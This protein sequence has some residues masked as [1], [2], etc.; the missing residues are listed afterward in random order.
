MRGPRPTLTTYTSWGTL[1]VL[2]D[3]AETLLKLG[4]SSKWANHRF[5]CRASE[6]SKRRPSQTQSTSGPSNKKSDRSRTSGYIRRGTTDRIYSSR[7][8]VSLIIG[9]KFLAVSPAF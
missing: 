7:A 8:T 9:R 5:R 6:L 3:V 1:G 2:S 4:N